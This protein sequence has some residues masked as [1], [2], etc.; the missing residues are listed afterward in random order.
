MKHVK[1]EGKFLKRAR[2]VRHHKT[3]TSRKLEAMTSFDDDVT[4]RLLHK[5]KGQNS[6]S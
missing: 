5:E 1:N 3:M 4:R 6:E 2:K